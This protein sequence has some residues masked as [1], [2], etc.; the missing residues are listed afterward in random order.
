MT[1]I[2]GPPTNS[3]TVNCH[4]TK[5]AMMMPSSTTK[6]VAAISKAMAAVKFAPFRNS[7]RAR[8]TAA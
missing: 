7:E 1:I 3:P 4:P 8:A 5:S 2:S 6:F